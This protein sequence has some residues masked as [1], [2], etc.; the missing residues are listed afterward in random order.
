MEIV[1]QALWEKSIHDEY[2]KSLS[3]QSLG[4][5]KLKAKRSNSDFPS[6]YTSASEA[7]DSGSPAR[8]DRGKSGHLW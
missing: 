6:L 7:K 1:N 4:K 2:E 5:E 8:G 3:W